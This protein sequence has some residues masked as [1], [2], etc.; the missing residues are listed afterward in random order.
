M[1]TVSYIDALENLIQDVLL[2][3]YIVGC[4]SVGRDPR[5][6]DIIT[7]LME[8]RRLKREVCVLLDPSHS[9]KKVLKDKIC[10]T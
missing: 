1:K 6:N 9:P 10:K 4:R 3:G 7:R 8:C 5:V 2:P